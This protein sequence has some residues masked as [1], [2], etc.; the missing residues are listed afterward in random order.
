MLDFFASIAFQRF[1]KIIYNCCLIGGR[2]EA[3]SWKLGDEL[4]LNAERKEIK[5][6]FAVLHR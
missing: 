2:K 1:S 5:Y 6:F 4:E 3:R